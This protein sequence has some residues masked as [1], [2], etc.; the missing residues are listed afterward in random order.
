M[1]DWTN[2]NL[3]AHLGSWNAT[4]LWRPPDRRPWL[5][6]MRQ[7]LKSPYLRPLS[8]EARCEIVLEFRIWPDDPAYGGQARPHG[9]DLDNLVKLTI[10][11]LTP[12]RSR[13]GEYRGVGIIPDDSSV[14]RISASKQLA[15]SATETGAWITVSTLRGRP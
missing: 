4:R 9:P 11:G 2:G 5:A 14:Y 15:H 7:A 3:A 12:H 13:D 8:G 10:D 6:A 1:V